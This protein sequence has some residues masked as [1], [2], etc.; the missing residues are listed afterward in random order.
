MS[1]QN[2]Y[3][4]PTKLK[5]FYNIPDRNADIPIKIGIYESLGQYIYKQDC[6]DFINNYGMKG[7]PANF[8]YV[9]KTTR[10]IS[11]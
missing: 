2:V 4:T 3:S 6:I 8:D 9:I 10:N 5:Q 1:C 11:I 7:V